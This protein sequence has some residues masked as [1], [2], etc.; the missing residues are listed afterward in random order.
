[1]A[2]TDPKRTVA[3][4]ASMGQDWP[5]GPIAKALYIDGMR[6]TMTLAVL[7]FVSGCGEPTYFVHGS[8]F[9]Q[10][11][12]L[13]VDQTDVRV[14]QSLYLP[15][16]RSSQGWVEVAASKVDKTAEDACYWIEEP[17]S[18]EQDVSLN[19]G[20]IVEP[21]GSH[22][23]SLYNNQHDTRSIV[24]DKP[25]RYSIRAHSATWCPPGVGSETIQVYVQ[26]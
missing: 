7:F 14:G 18:F 13:A 22:R 6:L 15:V 17:P 21:G 9:Q 11:I 10:S 1:M 12:H 2:A 19:V 20:F 8:D 23:L 24:F 5:L 26:D 16:T 25:G 4:V 3:P